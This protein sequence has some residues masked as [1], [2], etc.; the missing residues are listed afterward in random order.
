MGDAGRSV[1]CRVRAKAIVVELDPSS[2]AALDDARR[3]ALRASIRAE[4]PLDMRAKPL[5]FEPYRTGS[6]FLKSQREMS[7]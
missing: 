3:A 7:A 1:R 4:T 5:A 6:A 2:L